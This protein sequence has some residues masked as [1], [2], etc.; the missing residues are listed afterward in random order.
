MAKQKYLATPSTPLYKLPTYPKNESTRRDVLKRLL[1]AGSVVAGASSIYNSALAK[2]ALNDNPYKIDIINGPIPTPDQF[3]GP[4]YPVS[5]PV[6][7]GE[8]MTSLPGSDKP[9]GQAIFVTGKVTNILGEPCPNVRLEIW[10]CNAAGKYNHQNDH[11]P[12]AIDPNFEGYA[13]V[14]AD[15]N[16][17]FGFKTVR[18]G[19]YP[20][21][22]DFW[23]PPHIH[24]DISGRVNRLVT[25]MYF[26]G[27][28]LNKTDPILQ[29]AWANHTLIAREGELKD[30]VQTY[31]WDI[32]LIEG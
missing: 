23:R 16:G 21:T 9:L 2:E 7:G 15:E 6:D 28:K 14:M 8:D 1:A 13:N 11:N 19:S 12:A 31:H 18:P 10:Q 17:H 25:Q 4:Y 26:P 3:V 27:E 30:N 5:E 20:I 29:V 22:D 32:M 24:F